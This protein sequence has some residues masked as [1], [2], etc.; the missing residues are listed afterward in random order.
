MPNTTRLIL[1]F[2]T[3]LYSLFIIGQEN[4]NIDRKKY[5]N[6]SKYTKTYSH[7]NGSIY[8]EYYSRKDSTLAE[9]ETRINGK[10]FGTRLKYYPNGQIHIQE[11]F[12]N[13]K[14]VGTYVEYYQNGSFK[15]IGHFEASSNIDDS[16]KSYRDSSVITLEDNP[17]TMI[18]YE[19]FS[20]PKNGV[21][22]YFDENNN[23]MYSG[24]Y[25]DNLREG[26]WFYYDNGK[27]SRKE[28]YKKGV[29]QL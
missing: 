21:W 29:K 18:L 13:D 28:T 24:I 4:S 8:I 20:S 25:T 9:S 23:L 17:A 12:I 26:E 5:E 16:E 19:F 6:I 3:C 10:L 27:I 15:V 2:V 14:I 11:T 1:T 22:E 7:G